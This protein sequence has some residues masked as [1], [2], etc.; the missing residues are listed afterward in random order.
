MAVAVVL[1][2]ARLLL[3]RVALARTTRTTPT[4]S[5]HVL[6]ALRTLRALRRVRPAHAMLGT[7][8]MRTRKPMAGPDVW[9]A[10]PIPT[11]RLPQILHVS[12]AT[13]MQVIRAVLMD[14]AMARIHPRVHATRAMRAQL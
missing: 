13:P 2:L 3:S 9:H 14:L 7:V 12:H 5:R 6:R 11:N 10:L 8:A 4:R 1:P